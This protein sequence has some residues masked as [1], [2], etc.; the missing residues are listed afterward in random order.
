MPHVSSQSMLGQA[1][2]NT[3][4]DHATPSMTPKGDSVARCISSV[5]VLVCFAE[6]FSGA[7][8]RLS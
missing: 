8:G 4:S 3:L 6:F 2:P 5:G 7:R 1:W